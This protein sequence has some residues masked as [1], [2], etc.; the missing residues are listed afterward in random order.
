MRMEAID[1]EK[2]DMV[3][4]IAGFERHSKIAAQRYAERLDKNDKLAQDVRML[5]ASKVESYKIRTELMA[6]LEEERESKH[7]V[8]DDTL[9]AVVNNDGAVIMKLQVDMEEKDKHIQKRIDM[10]HQR[11]LNEM[12]TQEQWEAMGASAS[13][14]TW[15]EKVDGAFNAVR[16]EECENKSAEM[17]RLEC[18]VD[19]EFAAFAEAWIGSAW[20]GVGFWGWGCDGVGVVLVGV[21]ILK[22]KE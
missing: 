5:K 9:T 18:A 13:G 6:I 10:L 15:S 17:L 8:I 22:L 11:A 3:E 20:I 7:K 1:E 21:G 19:A 12:Q 2:T 16:G 4:A 14:A